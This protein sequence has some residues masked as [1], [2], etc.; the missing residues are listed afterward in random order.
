[1]LRCCKP[2]YILMKTRNSWKGKCLFST[3]HLFEQVIV[4]SKYST[5]SETLKIQ[6]I[7]SFSK[8][9]LIQSHFQIA[10]SY[11]FGFYPFYH[12]DFVRLKHTLHQWRRRRRWTKDD[13]CKLIRRS[14]KRKSR[15]YSNMCLH[16]LRL[17]LSQNCF[18]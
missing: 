5:L 6:E 14:K 9:F 15:L 8:H 10:L 3:F 4:H 18:L 13:N 16:H 17:L 7:I 11:P 1:M 12:H 2:Y